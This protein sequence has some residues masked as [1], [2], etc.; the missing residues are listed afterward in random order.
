MN[1]KENTKDLIT[2]LQNEAHITNTLPTDIEHAFNMYRDLVNVRNLKL[3][4]EKS[5]NF[6]N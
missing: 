4:L 2:Y 1:L 3:L 6:K 5:L